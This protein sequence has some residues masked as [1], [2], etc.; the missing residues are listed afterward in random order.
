MSHLQDSESY[1]QQCLCLAQI[2]SDPARTEILYLA[3]VNTKAYKGCDGRDGREADANSVPP[4]KPPGLSSTMSQSY[5]EVGATCK[6]E[7]RVGLDR[8]AS[9]ALAGAS[10]LATK[11]VTDHS[12]DRLDHDNRSAVGRSSNQAQ[13][14]VYL[15][16]PEGLSTNN[17][18]EPVQDDAGEAERQGATLKQP[19]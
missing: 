7:L 10:N 15:L 9:G 1:Q 3:L 11:A 18:G 17:R 6:A 14:L 19:A 16:P 8:G 5:A 12:G 13:A 2:P 4:D